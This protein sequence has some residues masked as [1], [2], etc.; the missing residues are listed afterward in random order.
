MFGSILTNFKERHEKMKLHLH[1]QVRLSVF[2]EA[3]K[4]SSSNTLT[5]TKIAQKEEIPNHVSKGT[6]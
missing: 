1:F 5:F 6:T 2:P 4:Y 3:Q